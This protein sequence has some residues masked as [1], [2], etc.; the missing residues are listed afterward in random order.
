MAEA[1]VVPHLSTL[2]EISISHHTS[3]H[4]RPL[5]RLDESSQVPTEQSIREP[6]LVRDMSSLG[7]T[8]RVSLDYQTC[9]PSLVRD[10]T[11]YQD[12]AVGY[13]ELD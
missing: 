7:E 2:F 9:E 5:V 10:I 11:V 4:E 1:S 12:I 13:E 6:F 3:V 8:N